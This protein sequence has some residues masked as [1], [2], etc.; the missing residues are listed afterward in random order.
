MTDEEN[1]VFLVL[2][3]DS[4]THALD[5]WIQNK[6]DLTNREKQIIEEYVVDELG[7]V[8]KAVELKEHPRRAEVMT[9]Q[10]TELTHQ[11]DDI[12]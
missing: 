9:I 2:K 8:L 4:L 12:I 1:R 11:D 5:L 3:Y 6:I 7:G 10:G